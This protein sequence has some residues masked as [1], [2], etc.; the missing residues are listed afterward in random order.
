M[1]HWQITWQISIIQ[2]FSS[3]WLFFTQVVLSLWNSETFKI[4]KQFKKIKYLTFGHSFFHPRHNGQW[5]PTSNPRFYPLHYFLILILEKEPVFPF[6]MLIAKQ[7]KYWYHFWY[8][9][10][11][12]WGLNPGPPALDASTLPLGYRGGSQ[13][14]TKTFL[15]KSFNISFMT[16]IIMSRWLKNQLV[17][18]R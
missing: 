16:L 8:E 2:R 5:P 10:V 11:L 3:F 18:Q 15:M 17:T 9:A 4:Q 1:S 6:S 7:A 12:D 13:K 14:Q